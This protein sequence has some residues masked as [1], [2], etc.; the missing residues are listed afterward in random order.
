VTAAVGY[1]DSET[2]TVHFANAGHPYP[3]HYFAAADELKA[4]ELPSTPLGL[5]LPPELQG[6]W[7]EAEVCL[8]AGDFLVFYS[9]GITDQQSSSGEFFEDERLEAFL[10]E[11]RKAE[12]SR[13]IAGLIRSLREFQGKSSQVDDLTVLVLRMEGE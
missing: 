3:Y 1:V 11:N 10:W 7:S 9:D 6:N 13:L 4:L 5:S 2:S 8:E 12:S